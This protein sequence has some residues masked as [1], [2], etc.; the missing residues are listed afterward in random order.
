MD[1]VFLVNGLLLRVASTD[2]RTVRNFSQ[3]RCC[4]GRTL[5]KIV[6]AAFIP[7][8]QSPPKCGAQAGEKCQ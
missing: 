1:I 8:S 4:A 7:A 2:V 3:V 6:F 5:F